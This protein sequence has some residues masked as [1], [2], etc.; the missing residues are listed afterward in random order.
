M[1]VE[2]SRPVIAVD[3]DDVL[4]PHAPGLIGFLNRSFNAN[5]TLD[6]FFSFED[7]VQSAGGDEGQ[8]VEQ[9]LC[10]LN[11]VE[12]AGMGPIE[13]AVGVI[14]GL[15]ER[16]DLVIIT[17]RPLFIE[18]MTRRWLEEHFPST[19]CSAHFV[20]L[21]WEWGRGHHASKM[22]VCR[23]ERVEVLIDD[24]PF[25]IGEA[26]RS[27]IVGLLFGNYPWNMELPEGAERVVDWAAVSRRLL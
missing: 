4:V 2:H 16:Y 6:R 10:F 18:K 21:D 15:K 7:I 25:Q 17:A 26:I 11:S 19:F 8:V 24:S 23:S 20:N 14:E 3:V 9:T 27:G 22:D 5:I 13:E 1:D 12:F